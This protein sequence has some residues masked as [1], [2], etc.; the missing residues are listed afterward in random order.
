VVWDALGS[1][2]IIAYQKSGRA[3]VRRVLHAI[4]VIRAGRKRTNA[5]E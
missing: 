1:S 2:V 4:Y 3:A 5:K